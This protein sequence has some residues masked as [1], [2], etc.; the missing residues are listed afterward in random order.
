MAIL[1]S[2]SARGAG[3][4]EGSPAAV[5]T[6][7]MILAVTTTTALVVRRRRR[8]RRRQVEDARINT[9]VVR[10]QEEEEQIF[11]LY[12]NNTGASSLDEKGMTAVDRLPETFPTSAPNK[13]QNEQTDHSNDGTEQTGESSLNSI[14]L[15][16]FRT[17][18]FE[19]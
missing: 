16:S 18:R 2:V 3:G 6:W 12:D 9:V 7:A 5:W 4:K 10:D 17:E 1:N 19:V 11:D 13:K 15:V 14:Q 8:R